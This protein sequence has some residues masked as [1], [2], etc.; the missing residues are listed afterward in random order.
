MNS[1]YKT[2]LI[3]P[4]FQN[5]RVWVMPPGEFI[6]EPFF[7]HESFR[8]MFFQPL[9]AH[10]EAGTLP[11]PGDQLRRIIFAEFYR[12]VVDKDFSLLKLPRHWKKGSRAFICCEV[13]IMVAVW[14]MLEVMW[15]QGTLPEHPSVSLAK[16]IFDRRLILLSVVDSIVHEN[17][18]TKLVKI[19]QRENRQLQQLENPFSDCYT[20]IFIDAAIKFSDQDNDFRKKNYQV[21]VRSRMSLTAMFEEGSSKRDYETGKRLEHR[22]RRKAKK[23]S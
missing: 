9:L 6:S 10:Q 5:S 7:T 18:T 14:E 3:T 16:F 4:D 17:T 23:L 2:C 8:R 1:S 13:N 21:M 20:S 12:T 15:R 11:E 19:L 22:G